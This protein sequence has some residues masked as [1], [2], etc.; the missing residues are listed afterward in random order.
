MNTNFD[1]E[2][3]EIRQPVPAFTL[4]SAQEKVRKAEDGWNSQD[5][6]KVATAE[7]PIINQDVGFRV[8]EQF[9]FKAL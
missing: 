7:I 8:L 6:V 2:H 4:L 9:Q 5:P 1:I 3:E